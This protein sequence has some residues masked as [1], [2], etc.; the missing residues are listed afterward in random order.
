MKLFAYYF[1]TIGRMMSSSV[2]IILIIAS[3]VASIDF[4]D[5]R[6]A[7]I[8]QLLKKLNKPALK[9]IKVY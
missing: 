8:D 4:S 6:D 3:V 5:T 7:E 2:L 9:S 1:C